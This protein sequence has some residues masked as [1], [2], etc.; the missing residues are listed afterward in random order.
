MAKKLSAVQNMA[1][2]LS[3]RHQDQNHAQVLLEP[4]DRGYGHTLGNAL[5]RILLSSMPGYAVT[6]IAI[7][8]VLHEYS[9]IDGVQDDVID[10][11]LNVKGILFVLHNHKE[12]TLTLKVK[13]PCV[14]KASDIE[15]THDVEI[16]NP[17]H[18]IATITQPRTFEMTLVVEAGSGYV[19]AAQH[20]SDEGMTEVGAG[21]I[22]VDASFSPIRKVSY[23]V[24]NARVEQRTDLDKLILDIE[25]N[26]AICPET[27]VRKAAKI[28]QDQLSAFVS[29]EI[30]EEE[31]ETDNSAGIDPLMLRPVEDLELTVRSANCLKSENI[32]LIGELVRK[33][34]SELLKAPNLGKKSLSEIKEVLSS[35]G[36]H[37]G[38]HIANWPTDK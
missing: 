35:R 37:L 16:L 17:D 6:S 5:R 20:E 7:K 30:E 24:D 31:Q 18:V 3:V 1:R 27:A 11:I 21:K 9:A 28:L 2:N 15:L 4:L 14:V 25:T 38:M 33:T 19:P 12:A 10:I 36:L 34:E 29:L 26:G 8:D 23:S 22:L 32:N 13:G